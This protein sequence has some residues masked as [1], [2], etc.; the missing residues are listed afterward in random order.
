M[1]EVGSGSELMGASYLFFSARR[2]R[3]SSQV[4]GVGASGTRFALLGDKLSLRCYLKAEALRAW[5]T[6]HG[7]M[8]QT[9][10]AGRRGYALATVY[11]DA[12]LCSRPLSTLHR[13]LHTPRSRPGAS[14]QH[15]R[16]YLGRLGAG[17]ARG[18]LPFFEL[19]A[20]LSQPIHGPYWRPVV[21][22]CSRSGLTGPC[23][24]GSADPFSR[25]TGVRW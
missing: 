12:S 22:N 17:R 21:L 6:S 25:R 1:G 9:T 14:T 3:Q 16:G 15:P 5:S 18:Q 4:A 24:C 19:S 10:I 11:T 23:C 8:D 20:R 2:C 7:V 13:V